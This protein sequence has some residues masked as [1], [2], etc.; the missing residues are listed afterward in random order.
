MIKQITHTFMLESMRNYGVGFGNV[1]P[2]FI[3]L[4]CPLL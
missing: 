4:S 3:F 2:A 1:L